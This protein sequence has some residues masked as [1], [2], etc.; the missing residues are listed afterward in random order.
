MEVEESSKPLLDLFSRGSNTI[1]SLRRLSAETNFRSMYFHAGHV[2]SCSF[3]AHA[4]PM[5]CLFFLDR[6]SV[7]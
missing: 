5:T 1:F 2:I 3:L 6:K 7:V 4:M